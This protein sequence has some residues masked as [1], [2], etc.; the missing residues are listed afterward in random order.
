MAG[1]PVTAPAA[2]YVLAA[3]EGEASWFLGGLLT[4]KASGAAT[5]G[6]LAVLE[7]L[8]RPGSTTPRHV[9]WTEDE[10]FYVLAGALRGYCGDQ[11]WRA[12]PG[13]F[14]WLPRGVPHGFTNEGDQPVRKLI[15][16][17]PAGFERFVAEGGEPAQARGFPPPGRAGPPGPPD[18]EKLRAA[19]ARHGQEILGPPGT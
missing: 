12:G 8:G 19:A 3:D 18:A 5:R 11:E 17:A 7:S 15:I 2:H 9:H 1:D 10:A 4:V 16:T 13:A 14:V 6:A